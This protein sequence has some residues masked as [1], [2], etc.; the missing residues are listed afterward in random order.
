MIT[1]AD[2]RRASA[3]LAAQRHRA[4]IAVANSSDPAFQ[5][6]CDRKTQLFAAFYEFLESMHELERHE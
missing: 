6:R 1:E 4:S 5:E 2:L 3:V